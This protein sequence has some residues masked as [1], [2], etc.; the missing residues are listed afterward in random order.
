MFTVLESAA[1]TTAGRKA[2]SSLPQPW[3]MGTPMP[4]LARNGGWKCHGPHRRTHHHWEEKRESPK[5][6]EYGVWSQQEKLTQ[7]G[8]STLAQVNLKLLAIPLLQTPVCWDFSHVLSLYTFKH[9][10]FLLSLTSDSLIKLFTVSLILLL[11]V[12]MTKS[13]PWFSHRYFSNMWYI[14]QL[15]HCPFICLLQANIANTVVYWVIY[16]HY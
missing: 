9:I 16:F 10:I 13:Q 1:H 12:F 8:S 3:T 5:L 2:V 15:I 6:E 14:N 11:H 4:D 7:L